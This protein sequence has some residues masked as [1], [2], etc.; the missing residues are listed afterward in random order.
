MLNLSIQHMI[1]LN[2]EQRYALHNGIELV[3]VGVSVPVWFM[4][5]VTSEPAKEVFCKYYLKN[6]KQDTP[7]A[8]R[9]D[10]YEITVPYR[11]GKSLIVTDDEWRRLNREEPEKLEALYKEQSL[12]EVSSKNLLDV[13]DGGCRAMT[14]REH[15]KLQQ[16][17][18][19]LNVVHFVQI[20]AMDNLLQTL[21]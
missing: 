4:D 8:V 19:L 15:S 1:H 2:K 11:E 13:R 7:I 21:A 9:E 18:K 14:Y 10:G 5:R 16:D 3:V 17:K 12:Q 20:S 6:T